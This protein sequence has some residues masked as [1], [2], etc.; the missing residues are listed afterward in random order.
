MHARDMVIEVDHPAHG[1]VR[2]LGSMMKLDDTALE[3]RQWMLG[4]GQNTD[5]ILEEHGFSRRE[6]SELREKCVV[7]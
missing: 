5:E 2:T 3:I 1:R 7:A 4:P 6:I